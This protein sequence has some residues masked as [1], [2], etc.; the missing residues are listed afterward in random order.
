MQSQDYV[1][2]PFSEK[3]KEVAGFF[4]IRTAGEPEYMLHESD[5]NK[6]VRMYLPYVLASL[7]MRDQSEASIEEAFQELSAYIFGNNSTKKMM[8]ITTP[9][10]QEKKDSDWHLCFILPEKMNIVTAP[11]PNNKKFVLSNGQ[12]NLSQP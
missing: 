5:G 1:S 2:R 10:L 4:G 9:I 3:V 8:E 11:Q 7:P 6:E 12:M